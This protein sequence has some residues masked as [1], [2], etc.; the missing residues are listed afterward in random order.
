VAGLAQMVDGILKYNTVY[1]YHQRWPWV[2]AEDVASLIWYIIENNIKG[3]VKMPPLGFMSLETMAQIVCKELQKEP[4]VI[5]VNQ[6]VMPYNNEFWEPICYWPDKGSNIG[7]WVPD[8]PDLESMVRK[9]ASW[10][11]ANK[12]ALSI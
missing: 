12:W 8:S 6:E 7:D 1:T 9:T 5:E 2:Y 3:E 4:R 11:Q 10:Y